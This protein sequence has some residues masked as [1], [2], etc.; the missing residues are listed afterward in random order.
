MYILFRAASLRNLFPS[1]DF[2]NTE[3]SSVCKCVFSWLQ[4]SFGSQSCFKLGRFVP[5]RPVLSKRF[6]VLHLLLNI[7]PAIYLIKLRQFI[8]SAGP[9]SVLLRDLAKIF[10]LAVAFL[11]VLALFQDWVYLPLLLKKLKQLATYWPKK[12]PNAF[13]WVQL[14]LGSQPC[15]KLGRVFSQ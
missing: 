1:L 9:E 8:D 10:F 3:Y 2:L 7:C 12:L 6:S 13:S 15:F 11:G 14:S 5:Q 4:P